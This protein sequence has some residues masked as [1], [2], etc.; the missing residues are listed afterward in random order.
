[1]PDGGLGEVALD[2]VVAGILRVALAWVF[3]QAAYHKLRD[4]VGFVAIVRGYAL[5]PD[6][7]APFVTAALLAGETSAAGLLVVPGLAPAG[8]AL[9]AA[10][11]LVYSTAIGV[12]LARGR[13]D[14]DCGCLGPGHRQPL[15]GWLLVR[16][17]ALLVMALACAAPV[18]QRAIGWLDAATGVGG[19]LV[20]A[21]LL[22]AVARLAAVSGL[23]APAAQARG[24]R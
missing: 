6:R 11:L 18:G 23:A 3:A 7:A 2:P 5:L 15:S 12:N 4:P 13:R 9:V 14:V 1:M 8:A 17:A 20:T 21:L 22:S 24:A 10:L 19:V 16:N